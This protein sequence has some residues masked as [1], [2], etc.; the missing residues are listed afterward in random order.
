MKVNEIM[1]KQAAW[2]SLSSSALTAASIMQQKDVGMLPVAVDP[3]TPVLVGVVTDRDLCLHVVAEGRDPAHIWVSECATQD[4]VCC[5]ADDDV[6]QA[7]KL[8]KENHIRRLP[9]VNVKH[10][11]VGVVSLSD[12]IRKADLPEVEIVSAW[13]RICEPGRPPRKLQSRVVTAA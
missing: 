11:I 7:L 13:K 3:F 6:R 8:M 12:I 1:C 4:P 10:E 5:V 2:C 9:V